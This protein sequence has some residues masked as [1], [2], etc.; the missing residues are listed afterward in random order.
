MCENS[1]VD[2]KVIMC[3]F[4]VDLKTIA[5]KQDYYYGFKTYSP[6]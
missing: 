4:L 1:I 6:I 3:R 2:W 5:P